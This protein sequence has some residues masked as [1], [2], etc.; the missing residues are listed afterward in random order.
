VSVQTLWPNPVLRLPSH[1]VLGKQVNVSESVL[2]SVKWEE[3]SLPHI[4]I[5]EVQIIRHPRQ[6]WLGA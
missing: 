3:Y 1:I 5:D 6:A 2:S 4:V